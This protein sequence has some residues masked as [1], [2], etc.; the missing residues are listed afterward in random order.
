MLTTLSMSATI[1][2]AVVKP[3]VNLA[4]ESED[5]GGSSTVALA[6]FKCPSRRMT[7]REWCLKAGFKVSRKMAGSHDSNFFMPLKRK[8]VK[9]SGSRFPEEKSLKR[10]LK[11][12][13]Q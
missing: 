7:L 2:M 9:A 12:R 5:G 6:C 8:R 13:S 11:L 4:T 3:A 1:L 10:I